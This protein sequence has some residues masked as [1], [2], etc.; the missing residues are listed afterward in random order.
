[1]YDTVSNLSWGVDVRTHGIVGVIEKVLNITWPPAAEVGREVP[2]AL[3]EEDCV[4]R[5]FAQF[6]APFDYF[7]LTRVQECYSWEF[8][9]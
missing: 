9:E 2:E 7:V 5:L 4:V 8:G 3:E 1:V 6:L